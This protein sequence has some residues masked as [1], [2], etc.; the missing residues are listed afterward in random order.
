MLSILPKNQFIPFTVG[1][2]K[3]DKT[4]TFDLTIFDH[5]NKTKKYSVGFIG[6]KICQSKVTESLSHAKVNP[7]INLNLLKID[8]L[9]F[10]EFHVTQFT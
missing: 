5:K 3:S 7:K 8:D 1:T 2:S 9:I 4:K 6:Y 10:L